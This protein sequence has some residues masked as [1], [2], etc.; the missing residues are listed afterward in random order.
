MPN[1][2]PVKPK[3]DGMNI[4]Q[5]DLSD[6]LLLSSL[7]TDVQRLHAENHPEIF[8][9]PQTDDFAVLFFDEILADPVTTI[10]VAEREGEPLGYVLCKLIERQENP[11]TLAMRYLL[12]DQIS[13]RSA[14][15]GKGVGAALLKQADI[16]AKELKVSRIQLDSWGFNTDAHRFFE[17][18]GF[19]K[20]NQRFWRIL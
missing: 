7:C 14:E 18:M 9:M 2:V 1:K 6:S 15:Q 10:F 5:A 13:V 3:E 19:E 16:L 4:R 8:K 17:K 20:F 11:F 12:I